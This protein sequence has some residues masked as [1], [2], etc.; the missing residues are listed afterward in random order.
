MRITRSISIDES[1]L[2][3]RFVHSSGPGG[4]NVNKVATACQLRFNA[5]TCPVLSEAIRH[6]LSKIAGRR[7]T[8]DGVL[9]LDARR[10][11][12]QQRNR[13]D[14]IDR[15][16]GLLRRAAKPPAARRPTGG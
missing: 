4:Q 10:Y 12:R 15:L 1:E 11:R 7:M 2:D 8:A 9:V 3:I 14:A 16:V 13:E 5:A 6:R